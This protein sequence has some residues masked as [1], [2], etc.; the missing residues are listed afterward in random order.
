MRFKIDTQGAINKIN[1]INIF[2]GKAG[3]VAIGENQKDFI[4]KYIA[5]RIFDLSQSYVPV[6]TG[7]LKS[8]GK[9]VKN[10]IGTYSIVYTAP[11]GKFVHEIIGNKHEFPT[12]AKFLE[13]AGY[14]V[15]TEFEKMKISFG[16]TF[17]MDTSDDVALHLDSLSLE[18]FNFNR[19][20]SEY[21]MNAFLED[22]I[23]GEF[24]ELEDIRHP[25]SEVLY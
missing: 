11:Y 20:Y 13:D 9:I 10:N 22:L 21:T 25:E 16:F 3:I 18:D 7:Y 17:S 23:D 4:Y 24:R 8:T 1:N 19:N 2:Y 15:L 6:E 12:R 5:Q 14:E